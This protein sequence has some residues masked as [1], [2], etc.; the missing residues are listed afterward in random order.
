MPEDLWLA[1]GAVVVFLILLGLLRAFWRVAEPNEALIVSGLGAKAKHHLEPNTT[2]FKIVT[3]KGVLV[4]PGFQVAR[5][6]S[7]DTRVSEISVHCVTKQGIPV[8]VQGVVI[9]KVGDDYASIAKAARRFLDQQ[10]NMDTRIHSVFAGHM[11][12]IIGALTVE[13]L[14]RDRERLIT[15]VSRSSESEMIRLGLM[16]DSLQVHEIDDTTGYISNLGKPHAAAVAAAARI[17]QAQHDREATQAEQ[18]AEIE[19]AAAWRES[20]IKQAGFQAEIDE[21]SSRAS[22]AG[23][24]ADATARQEV[25]VEATKT[26]QLEADLAEQRLQSQV[27]KPADA[28][29]Y[30]VRILAEAERDAQLARAEANAKSTRIGGIAEAEAVQAKGLAEAETARAKAMA[31]ADG[32][33][34]RAAA[35]AENQ[36]AVIAQELAEKWPEIVE[37]A[38]KSFGNIDHMV[39]L[40]GAEGIEDLFAKALS[41]GGTGLGLAK[42]LM[43]AMNSNGKVSLPE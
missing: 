34:A 11:R 17:A 12:S 20:R 23:P 25:V 19:K 13:E 18:A 8:S 30:E 26:A 36:D 39:V 43:Q 7:L 33:K 4:L 27:R 16:V 28:K 3:G 2:G 32:I 24:L 31:E 5:R 9:Y 15:E 29:A 6:L 38:A 40:N 41:L 35:L 21:A 37:A 1:V 42:T 10:D 14:I 22:Q